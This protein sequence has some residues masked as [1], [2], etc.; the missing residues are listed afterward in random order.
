M[1]TT[2]VAAETAIRVRL[3]EQRKSQRW[4][5]EVL[6]VSP[7][8]LS[9]RMSGKKSFTTDDLD[10]I[11]DALGTDFVSLMSGVAA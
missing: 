4:L 7:Y 6:G 3:A 5:S 8:W 11:A 9:R 1:G 10:V 2:Q